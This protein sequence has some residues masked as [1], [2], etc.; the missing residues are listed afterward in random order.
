MDLFWT[1][2]ILVTWIGCA[3]LLIGIGS[4]LLSRFATRAS[5]L[6]RFWMGLVVSVIFLLSWHFFLR[7]NG[8]CALSICV[9]GAVGLVIHRRDFW[10][11]HLSEDR[12]PKILYA[13]YVLVCA[14]IAFRATGECTHFDTGFYGAGAVRWILSYPVVPGLAN[15]HSRLG[16]NSSVFLCTAVLSHGFWKDMGHLLFN[17]LLLCAIWASVL[18]S[19]HRLIKSDRLA[20][21]DLFQSCLL[22]PVVYWTTRGHIVGTMTDLPVSIVTLTAIG[23][24][25]QQSS[26]IGTAPTNPADRI[27][28]IILALSMLTLAVTFKLSIAV[29]ALLAWIFG[30]YQIERAPFSSAAKRRAQVGAVIISALLLMPWMAHGWVLSGYPLFPS[31]LLGIRADWA[32]SPAVGKLVSSLVQSYART[33]FVSIDRTVGFVWLK[34]W[35]IRNI[36][37]REGLQVP[38]LL[39]ILGGSILFVFWPKRKGQLQ[40]AWLLCAVAVGLGFW[41]WAAPAPRFGEALLWSM[42][43]IVTLEAV[44]VLSEK[45]PRPRI[46]RSYLTIVTLL[47]LYCI[48]PHRLWT[49]IYRPLLIGSGPIA[50]PGAS[51]VRVTD[52]TGFV[53]YWRASGVQCWD[54]PIPCTPY[55]DSTLT[56]RKPGSLRDGFRSKGIQSIGDMKGIPSLPACESGLVTCQDLSTGLMELDHGTE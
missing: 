29:F 23:I 10:Q 31:T 11:L 44:L 41:F 36:K 35:F 16:I 19:A 1:S 42:A 50:L 27:A 6:D 47:S 5:L 2:A 39:T 8:W 3:T 7:I 49:S 53:L 15:V 14:S 13:I 17:G 12:Y 43:G 20:P 48:A 25:V 30:L 33:P 38:L 26:N 22:I 9:I 34:P 21:G 55:Y 4:V 24:L 32:V 18:H 28:K 40:T 45:Y 46:V 37:G 51:V 56:L 54:A 52:A